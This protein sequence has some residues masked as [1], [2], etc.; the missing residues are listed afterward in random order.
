MQSIDSIETYA[1]GMRKDLVSEK[2]EIKCKNLIKRYN[3]TK[4]INFDDVTTENMKKH[5]PKL[6]QIPVQP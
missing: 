1:Y 5:N 4:M 2:K 3:I 6:P